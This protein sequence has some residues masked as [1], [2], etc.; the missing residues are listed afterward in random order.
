[1]FC[2]SRINFSEPEML[3]SKF[4]FLREEFSFLR[5]NYSFWRSDSCQNWEKRIIWLKK[6][7]FFLK[8]WTAES[9]YGSEQVDFSSTDIFF[10]LLTRDDP[11]MRS[12]SLLLWF[13]LP[14]TRYSQAMYIKKFLEF[15]ITWKKYS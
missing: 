7:K 13:L 11:T 15:P 9:F 8:K 4:S 14:W 12:W 5:S 2:A 1:M 6:C 3:D 10:V